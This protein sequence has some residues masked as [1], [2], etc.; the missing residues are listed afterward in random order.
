M[1]D[2]LNCP[3]C[4]WLLQVPTEY[5]TNEIRCPACE[6]VFSRATSTDVTAQAPKPAAP[7]EEE[8]RPRAR[9]RR[10][11]APEDYDV[12]LP[13][14]PGFRPAGALGLSLRILLGL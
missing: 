10:E 2:R 8:E 7:L 5:Q 14:G 1:S 12:A 13:E 11:R 3:L 4:G 6:G 9:T